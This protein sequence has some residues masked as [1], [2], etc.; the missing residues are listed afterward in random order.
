MKNLSNFKTR[1]IVGRNAKRDLKEIE[2]Y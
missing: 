2:M 1:V